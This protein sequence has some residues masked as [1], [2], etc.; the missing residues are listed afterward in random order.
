MDEKKKLE[1]VRK[2]IDGVDRKIVHLL[3]SRN[4][5]V[6]SVSLIKKEGNIQVLDGK[7]EQ[8]VMDGVL[9]N[10][11]KGGL[12]SGY[13]LSLYRIILKHSRNIQGKLMKGKKK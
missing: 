12:D 2:K 3:S 1:G 4:K 9:R 7:R 6:R 13:V 8:K 5:L 10:S 11:R